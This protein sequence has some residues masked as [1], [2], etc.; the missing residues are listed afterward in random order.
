MHDLEE[1]IADDVTQ[2]LAEDV[3]GGDLTAALIPATARGHARVI[4]RA[5]GVI[6]GCAWFE[7]CFTELDPDCEVFWHAEDGESVRADTQLCEITGNARAML[8]A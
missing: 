1:V 4:V 8:T 6:A 2:A 7:R 5:G 3:R